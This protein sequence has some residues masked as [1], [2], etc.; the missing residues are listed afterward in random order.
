M[1]RA[2]YSHGGSFT[3]CG[4]Q[5]DFAVHA[6]GHDNRG[7]WVGPSRH[8]QARGVDERLLRYDQGVRQQARHAAFAFPAVADESSELAVSAVWVDLDGNRLNQLR[9]AHS[10]SFSVEA[11]DARAH[12]VSWVIE[13]RAV[14]FEKSRGTVNG[15]LVQA[16]FKR[17]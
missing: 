3:H 7:I 12:D 14:M 4:T 1:A 11:T 15:L 17:V 2:C 9:L 13:L 16:L 8:K 6:V 5:R 10:I